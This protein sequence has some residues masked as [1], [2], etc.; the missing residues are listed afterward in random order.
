MY[1]FIFYKFKLFYANEKIIAPVL[2]FI[3]LT[4]SHNNW[5]EYYFS[6]FKTDMNTYLSKMFTKPLEL[7]L[8]DY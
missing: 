4:S 5:T 7:N 1:T 3:I 8:Y 2:F 6:V